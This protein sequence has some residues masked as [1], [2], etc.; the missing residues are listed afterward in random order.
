MNLKGRVEFL[1]LRVEF[2]ISD[3]VLLLGWAWCWFGRSEKGEF[4]TE[5][6]RTDWCLKRG[7]GGQ[8]LQ[9]LS[10]TSGNC[11]GIF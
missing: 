10:D 9:A 2:T 1:N 6:V 3:R 4:S 11:M 5:S 7:F 8:R